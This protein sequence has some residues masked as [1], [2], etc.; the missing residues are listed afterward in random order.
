VTHG[1]RWAAVFVTVLGDNAAEGLSC[2]KALALPVKTISGALFGY[3]AAR[4]LEQLLRE[5]AAAMHDNLTT[6]D[7]EFHGGI[8]S[9]TVLKLR[10]TPCNSVVKNLTSMHMTDNTM[11]IEY[12]I[13][14]IT[15]LVAKNQFKYIDIILHK[16]EERIDERAGTLMLTVESANP[17]GSAFEQELTRRIE[18]Q[19]GAKHIKIE[20]RLVPALLGGYRL[21]AGGLYVDASVKGQMDKMRADLE[22]AL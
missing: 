22:A 19:T 1:S 15:L 4:R 20:M 10:A 2:L 5:S 6:E 7:T 3:S 18:Q 8:E 17:L 21:R 13:R 9:S 16:I 14:F 11:I 12:A